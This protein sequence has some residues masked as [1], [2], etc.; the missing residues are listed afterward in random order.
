[1]TGLETENSEAIYSLIFKTLANVNIQNTNKNGM[2]KHAAIIF[3][4]ISNFSK[5]KELM[6]K[7]LF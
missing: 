2:I 1:M 4:A 6:N 3:G 5:R 7:N